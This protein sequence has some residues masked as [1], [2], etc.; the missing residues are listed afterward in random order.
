[1]PS[2]PAAVLLA[3]R[4]VAASLALEG[5]AEIIERIALAGM[6][7]ALRASL[8]LSEQAEVL[9]AELAEIAKPAERVEPAEPERVRG[10][11]IR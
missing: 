11:A 5:S 9:R 2:A 8:E 1:M 4:Y 10:G 6:K 3:A 7:D